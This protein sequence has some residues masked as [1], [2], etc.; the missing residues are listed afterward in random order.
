MAQIVKRVITETYADEDAELELDESDLGD[1]EDE[2][3]SDDEEKPR[4]RSRR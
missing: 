2:G 1:E 3:E 4:K